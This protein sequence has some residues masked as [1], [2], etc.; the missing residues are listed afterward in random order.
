MKD[1]A[2]VNLKA[3]EKQVQNSYGA[4][5]IQVLAKQLTTCYQDLD[6]YFQGVWVGQEG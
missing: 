4:E 3:E 1:S 6:A 2:I 5:E